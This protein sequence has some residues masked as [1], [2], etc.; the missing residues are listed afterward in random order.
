M[1]GLFP[2]F[3]FFNQTRLRATLGNRITSKSHKGR[4][5]RWTNASTVVRSVSEAVKK[6]KRKKEILSPG[7]RL[8]RMGAAFPT[9]S[10]HLLNSLGLSNS[11]FVLLHIVLSHF[12]CWRSTKIRGKNAPHPSFFISENYLAFVCIWHC[13][14]AQHSK[15][16]QQKEKKRSWTFQVFLIYFCSHPKPVTLHASFILLPKVCHGQI[17]RK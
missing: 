5:C 12:Q 16:K 3:Y 9:P 14:K 15:M 1:H 6:K 8:N 2:N 17:Y 4:G 11:S 13:L 10:N 7:D